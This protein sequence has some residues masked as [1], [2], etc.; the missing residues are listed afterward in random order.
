MEVTDDGRDWNGMTGG[1]LM[2]ERTENDI[3]RALLHM[4]I[5]VPGTISETHELLNKSF[6]RGD[7][8]MTGSGILHGFMDCHVEYYVPSCKAGDAC[9]HL[10]QNSW[11]LPYDGEV[12][13]NYAH[14]HTGGISMA[15][16]FWQEYGQRSVCLNKPTYGKF[17]GGEQITDIS[18]CRVGF[19]DKSTGQVFQPIPFKKGDRYD[20]GMLYQQDDKPHFGVMGFSVL[21]VHRTGAVEEKK[22]RAVN[23]QELWDDAR[24]SKRFQRMQ[25]Q[26]CESLTGG[27]SLKDTRRVAEKECASLPGILE[28][29]CLDV[30]GAAERSLFES[31]GSALE[32]EAVCS[33]TCGTYQKTTS[34]ATVLV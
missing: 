8:T 4:D 2:I 12:I 1:T 9:K 29:T 16:A 22:Q 32:A 10:L 31:V 18:E 14:Y 3:I 20:V 26:M 15:S 7:K 23:F 13:A 25:C 5:N 24:R 28:R 33:T 6:H 21:F 27:L 30:V 11:E 17:K 19:P 34:A